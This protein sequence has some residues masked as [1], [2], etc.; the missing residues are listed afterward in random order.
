MARP[1]H[2][3][4]RPPVGQDPAT[5]PPPPTEFGYLYPENDI[6][7]LVDDRATGE[8]A[9]S[10]LREAGVPAGDMDLIP[11]G[12]FVD[13]MRTLR[14]RHGLLQLLTFSDERDL[15]QGYVEG[16]ESG[17]HLVAVHAADP[18]VVQRVR[19]VLVANGARHLLH[20]ERFTVTELPDDGPA[21]AGDQAAAPPGGER[22]ATIDPGGAGEIARIALE[23]EQGD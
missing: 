18:S 22:A 20:W 10:A 14:Q 7:A 16:A 9:L 1:S 12:W 3:D 8:R 21:G 5:A 13:K 11:G 4:H 23:A 2:A 17:H 6:L 19:L 15:I